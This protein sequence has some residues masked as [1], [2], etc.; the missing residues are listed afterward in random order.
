MGLFCFLGNIFCFFV[1]VGIYFN[2]GV[3][4]Y[5]CGIINYYLDKEVFVFD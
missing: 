2:K 4:G 3:Y 1:I 5:C